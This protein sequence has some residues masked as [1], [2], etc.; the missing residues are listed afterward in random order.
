MCKR[1]S[2]F[3]R[4][5]EELLN[6][7]IAQA[8]K[9]LK[10]SRGR[11]ADFIAAFYSYLAKKADEKS[12][13]RIYRYLAS[14]VASDDEVADEERYLLELVGGAFG[15]TDKEIREYLLTSEFM[16]HQDETL[17]SERKDTSSQEMPVI[18]FDLK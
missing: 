3:I 13:H 6:G 10:S 11:N 18:K 8:Q 7:L 2:R 16:T 14:I 9:D 17:P 15:F 5:D 1:L 4:L 12:R